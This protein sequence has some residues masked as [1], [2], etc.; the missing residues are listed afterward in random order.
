MRVRLLITAGL[1]AL[2]SLPGPAAART[3]L[4][5]ITLRPAFRPSRL[6]VSPPRPVRPMRW[7]HE[8]RRRGLA[9]TAT[10]PGG[11]AV[12]GLVGAAD[13]A[14]VARDYGVAPVFLNADLRALE[15]SGGEQELRALDAAVGSDSRLRYVEPVRERATLHRRNDPLTTLVDPVSRV[16]YEWQ[17]SHVGVDRALN[18]DRGDP[19]ITVGVI[20]TGYGDV[21]DLSGKITRAWYFD[22]QATNA[23]DTMGH[24]TFVSSLI[25]ATNDDGVGMAG[26]CGGCRLM[27]VKDLELDSF[28]VATAI[29]T[30]TDAGVRVINMSFGGSGISLAE[31]DAMN[32]AISKGVLLVAAAGNEG[33]TVDYPAAYLQPAGGAPGYGLAVGA[34]DATDRPASWSSWGDHLSLLAPGTFTD[35]PLCNVGVLGALPAV[36]SLFDESCGT[37]FTNPLTGAR[38]GY[39]D[40]TSFA[41]PEAAGVAALVWAA[42][43]DLT[44][45]G[46]V[47][48]LLKSATRAPGAPWSPDHG[49][50]ILNAAAAVQLAT[51]KSTDDAV[52][53]GEPRFTGRVE[54]GGSASATADVTY[55]D[56]VSV[57]DA[58]ATCTAKVG[59]RALEAT[60][61]RIDNGSV[62]CTWNV[63]EADGGQRLEAHVDVRDTSSGATGARDFGADVLDVK[64]PTA[65]ALRA[66]GRYGRRLTLRFQVSEETDAARRLVRVYRGSKAIFSSSSDLGPVDSG[67]LRSLVWKAPSRR[68]RG[69]Y[70]FCVWAWDR[71]DNESDPSCARIALR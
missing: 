39:S 37:K 34:S 30:L 2:A 11:R 56:G 48:I 71:S 29:D 28:T 53:I 33:G 4:R 7:S 55:Q 15:V 20:D 54:G 69:A 62:H 46:V 6:Q 24:G 64:A 44:S 51:G 5:P 47:S 38:Y 68:A 16:P 10:F 67:A 27:V 18:V 41:A 59:D 70:K 42:R 50:G 23:L 8:R 66:S 65:R 19:A 43:P 36:A 45:A 63:P 57:L 13:A 26:F 61:Q 49:W 22:G 40:G 1:A 25:A 32:Y 31:K 3:P 17:F 58:T 35:K 21:P 9:S 60:E 12:V 14:A 52:V